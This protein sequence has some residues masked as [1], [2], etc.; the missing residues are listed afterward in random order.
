MSLNIPMCIISCIPHKN[1]ERLKDWETWKI[2]ARWSHLSPL[3]SRGWGTVTSCPLSSHQAKLRDPLM[4]IP[5][6]LHP[7]TGSMSW[8]SHPSATLNSEPMRPGPPVT[9]AWSGALEAV[10]STWDYAAFLGLCWGRQVVS[11]TRCNHL[12]VLNMVSCHRDSGSSGPSKEVSVVK[13]IHS[14]PV[15]LLTNAATK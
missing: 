5:A 14:L 10:L 3:C 8:A 13:T 9:A 15:L 6:L 2:S 4:L 12:T 1:P 11:Q 7:P